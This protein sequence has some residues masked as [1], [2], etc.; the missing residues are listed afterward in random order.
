MYTREL[1]LAAGIVLLVFLGRREHLDIAAPMHDFTTGSTPDQKKVVFDM[2]PAS[3]QRSA[4]LASTQ[5]YGSDSSASLLVSNF[6]KE[7]QGRVY[8]AS[9]TPITETMVETHVT[10]MKAAYTA[11]TLDPILKAFFQEA[12]SNG[13]A[14]RLLMTYIGLASG[15]IPIGSVPT[16]STG[17]SLPTVL[18]QMR[19]YLLEY[20]MTGKSQYKTAYDGLKAWMD[21]YLSDLST[22][23][24]RDADT[25]SADVNTYRS[26]NTEMTKTQTDFQTVK[27]QG[28]QLEDAYHTIKT[29][30][31]QTPLPDTTGLYVKGG[32]AVG[33]VVGAIALTLF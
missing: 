15:N 31:D 4:V 14:K 6:V 18:G 25:I 27:T 3:L 11:S 17:I 12:Y 2:A 29:Q 9:P 20:K 24:E 16:S 10:E 32:I 26:S 19:D 28:P 5:K 7:F 33:L 8:K 30:M 23:L 22:S 13:D 21:R 1:L